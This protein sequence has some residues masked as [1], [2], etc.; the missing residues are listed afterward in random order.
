MQEIAT[1][2]ASAAGSSDCSLVRD[3]N[4]LIAIN[5]AAR[6]LKADAASCDDGDSIPPLS[7]AHGLG[8]TS[9]QGTV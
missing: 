3:L 8:S 7:A 1:E 4:S 5:R 2:I 6:A 9:V